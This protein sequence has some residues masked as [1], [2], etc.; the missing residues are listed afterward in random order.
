MSVG[1]QGDHSFRTPAQ[2][3]R[4]AKLGR[5]LAGG[6][7]FSSRA[8]IAAVLM[9]DNRHDWAGLDGQQAGIANHEQHTMSMSPGVFA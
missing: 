7:A 4:D 1:R 3:T 5:A 2:G 6:A 8:T 9:K